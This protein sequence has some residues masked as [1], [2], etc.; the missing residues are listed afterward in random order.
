MISVAP[1]VRR[2]VWPIK[3][4]VPSRRHD[5]GNDEGSSLRVLAEAGRVRRGTFKVK[6]SLGGHFTVGI[7]NS[8]W[9]SSL[10]LSVLAFKSQGRQAS[11]A[12]SKSS[13]EVESGKFY[14]RRGRVLINWA[15][16]RHRSGA[17]LVP[18]CGPGDR[19]AS[20][21]ETPI[22]VSRGRAEGP[23]WRG[24]YQGRLAVVHLS[25]AN[26][27][28]GRRQSDA[29]TLESPQPQQVK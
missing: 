9:P 20:R 26:G 5:T 8:K 1:V 21:F 24:H 10:L 12:P 11:P 22:M 6:T 19:E 29:D 15:I 3:G 13:L 14:C 16:C 7:L 18:P 2:R 4:L 25:I 27:Q 28:W 17:S 23:G